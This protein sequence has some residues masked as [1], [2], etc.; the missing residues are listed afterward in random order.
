MGLMSVQTARPNQL[1]VR[2]MPNSRVAAFDPVRYLEFVEPAKLETTP[3]FP[4]L[5]VKGDG[6]DTP[7]AAFEAVEYVGNGP[8]SVFNCVRLEP[9][10]PKPTRSERYWITM[11]SRWNMV[12]LVY[13]VAGF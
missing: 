7:R 3:G 2:V 8:L 6:A 4:T 9:I 11:P 10:T 1:S 13:S 12:P 5:N